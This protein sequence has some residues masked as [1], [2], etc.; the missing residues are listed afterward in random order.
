MTK[1]SL[2]RLK[3]IFFLRIQYY[4]PM[5]GRFRAYFVKMGGVNV[6]NPNTCFIGEK[7]IFDSLYPEQ[8]EIGDHVHITTGVIIYTHLLDTSKIGIHWMK[9]SVRI[10]EYA[11]IGANT[12]ICNSVNIGK[13][14][15]VGAGSVITKDIPNNEIWA[16]NP[17]KL[18]KHRFE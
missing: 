3:N 10:E 6:A 17:V 5:S 9:G 18:I 1:Y 16:G 2:K 14:V 7:V 12:I 8:I 11:F 4:L 15:I 13:N